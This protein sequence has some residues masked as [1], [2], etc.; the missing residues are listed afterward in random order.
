MFVDTLLDEQA[1]LDSQL[2]RRPKNIFPPSREREE[3]RTKDIFGFDKRLNRSPQR[4][5]SRSPS[6][7]RPHSRS[8]S[9]KR[10]S[11]SKTKLTSPEKVEFGQGIFADLRAELDEI[12]KPHSPREGDKF[13]L[14][15]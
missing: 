15:F 11:P 14:A 9:T 3:N 8:P 6:K 2:V 10:V 12:E 7:K 1:A 5:H 4:P 13:N